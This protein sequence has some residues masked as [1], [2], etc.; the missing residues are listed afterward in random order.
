MRV[1]GDAGMVSKEN[2][3]KLSRGGGR[4]IVCVPV[5]RGGK[6]DRKVLSSR[7]RYREVGPNLRRQGGG[8]RRG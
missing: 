4:Y 3:R 7:G 1:R 5:Q 2:L 6:I 8:A